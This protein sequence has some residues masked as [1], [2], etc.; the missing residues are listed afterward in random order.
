MNEKKT[1]ETLSAQESECVQKRVIL[2][3]PLAHRFQSKRFQTRRKPL[4]QW[5]RHRLSVC[6]AFS[7]VFFCLSACAARQEVLQPETLASLRFQQNLNGLLPLDLMFLD[8]TGRSIRF[9]NCLRDK[10]AILVFGYYECPMLC[11]AVLN[12][13]LNALNDLKRTIGK[14]FDLIFVSIDP[15]E[16]P[17]LAAAKR[18]SY[19]R[20]YDRPG[21]QIGWHFLTG[22]QPSILQLS[23]AAGFPYAYEAATKQ[24]AHPA[25]ILVLTP[26]GRISKYLFGASYSPAEL[27]DALAAASRKQ[28]SSP[29]QDLLMLCFHYNPVTGKYGAAIMAL[30]R[31]F[32][33]L[34][35][36]GIAVLVF[37]AARGREPAPAASARPSPQ[38]RKQEIPAP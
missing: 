29:I 10:P 14:D 15:A 28:I 11:S 8:E 26:E 1:S 19:L 7:F 17:R 16:T 22:E 31:V 24:Y 6:L 25:G 4:A 34:T 33:L 5:I 30:V 37:K 20:H 13:L 9:G 36:G 38:T 23:K 3:S 27:N 2:R 32:G 12:G 21:A 35:L 18:A